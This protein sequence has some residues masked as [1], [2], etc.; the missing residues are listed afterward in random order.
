MRSV[1]IATCTSGEPV[2]L[3]P[4]ACSL[5]SACLRSAVIDI[6][7]LL[8][9]SKVEPPDDPEAVGRGFDQSDRTSV[10]CRQ[11]KPRL[12]GETGKPLPMTEQLGLAG[13]D[14]EGRDVV[15]RRLK[16]NNRPI[17][18]P[19]LSG[20]AQKVQRN[21]LIEGERAGAGTP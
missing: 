19:R 6:G 16:R 17:E 11:L 9:L 7:S 21:G 8:F 14:G 4:C 12:C 15:Q 10:L 13:G 2:S 1:R 20:F 3:L 18:L 5:I